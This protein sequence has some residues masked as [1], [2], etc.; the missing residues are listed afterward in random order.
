ML[1]SVFM[2][3]TLATSLH[4][5]YQ[6]IFLHQ[7]MTLVFPLMDLF[8][9]VNY[10]I[11]VW[12]AET[13]RVKLLSYWLTG[14]DKVWKSCEIHRNL[15][16]KSM[17]NFVPFPRK[18]FLV[19][20]NIPC[21]DCFGWKLAFYNAHAGSLRLPHKVRAPR[22]HSVLMFSMNQPTHPMDPCQIQIRLE[23]SH[24]LNDLNDLLENLKHLHSMTI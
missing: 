15:G 11:I 22:G 9:I 2:K 3:G 20:E 19:S 6:S 13:E 14:R 7:R 17:K 12:W 5:L 1:S 21:K 23:K 10:I 18:Q 24:N 8:Y 4:F 16:L